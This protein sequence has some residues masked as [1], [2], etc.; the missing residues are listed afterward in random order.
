MGCSPFKSCSTNYTAPAPNPSPSRWTMIT[1]VQLDNA[2]V[3]KV[4][5][6]DCNNFEGVKI[7]VYKGQYK[8]RA[9]LDPHFEDTTCSPIAR[10]KPTDEGWRLAVDL[11]GRY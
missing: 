2:Y 3:L 6:H 8:P 11:C 7:M 4:R 10:F 5:Y 1:K 9:V